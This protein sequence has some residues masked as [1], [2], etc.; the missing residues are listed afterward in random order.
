LKCITKYGII[1]K[2]T[3][4]V[5]VM[6]KKNSE[7]RELINELIENEIPV[8][9]QLMAQTLL[10]FAG[11]T[12][13]VM[14]LLIALKKINLFL[15][16]IEISVIASFGIT[17]ALCL[18][19]KGKGVAFQY[20]LYN[21][22][23]VLLLVLD[24]L[25]GYKSKILLGFPIF[26]SMR[27]YNK[28]FTAYVSVI[29]LLCLLF[30][31]YCNAYFYRLTNTFDLSTVML[32][33]T[34]TVD[35]DFL[36]ESVANAK[37]D[38]FTMLISGL[39]TSFL[40]NAAYLLIISW[41]SQRLIGLSWRLMIND[42]LLIKK[43]ANQQIELSNMRQRIMISQVKPH[44]I[45][46]ALSSI[47]CLCTKNPEQAKALTL[48]F[49]KYLRHNL[50]TLDD[51]SLPT[52]PF[53]EELQHIENYLNI[54][55]IRFNEILNIEYSIDEIDFTVPTLSIQPLVENAVKHGICKREE[56]GTVKIS[57][58]KKGGQYEIIIED[59]GVGF[60][61]ESPETGSVH[62]GLKNIASRLEMYGGRL[63]IK[64][65]VGVGTVARVTIPCE[66]EIC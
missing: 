13:I 37:P 28:R 23:T 10:L 35:N 19:K 58:A 1:L 40:P 27:Y 30:S 59:D 63:E 56:G 47:A 6:K 14:L 29:V 65:T 25:S 9:N 61:T 53:T 33:G 45:Y 62:I 3:V 31:V 50:N 11:I 46:N 64:S 57:S 20:I 60:N 24:I 49:S 18:I 36:Y 8:A 2:N 38:S 5:I 41:L 34:I 51:S 32:D 66:E 52:C 54:E 21:L 42:E 12:L 26:L 43:E 17:S 22:F 48:N 39:F 55:K 7:R 44:F 16:V 15:F 4:E